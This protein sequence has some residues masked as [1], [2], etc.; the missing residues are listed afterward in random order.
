MGY[1]A[2][3]FWQ[4]ITRQDHERK[5]PRFQNSVALF[6]P[7]TPGERRQGH[8]AMWSWSE[9]AS[10]FF[11]QRFHGHLTSFDSLVLL[12]L[13]YYIYLLCHFTLAISGVNQAKKWSQ[14]AVRICKI[15]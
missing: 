7:E 15:L 6:R 9:S 10:Y 13:Y 14:Y 4:K 11:L 8:A 3:S 12:I 1:N 2:C 5:E